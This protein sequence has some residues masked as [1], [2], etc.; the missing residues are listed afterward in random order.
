MWLNSPTQEH[1]G[2]ALEEMPLQRRRRVGG[3]KP[4]GYCYEEGASSTAEAQS[5]RYARTR[6]PNDLCCVHAGGVPVPPVD[7]QPE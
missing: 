5:T 6:T 7:G 2:E 3:V 1:A 4:K